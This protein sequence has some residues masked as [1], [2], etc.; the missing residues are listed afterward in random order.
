MPFFLVAVDVEIVV[1]F[2]VV[3]E[4]VDQRRV[5][6]KGED[7]RP[8]LGE[9]DVEFLIGQAVV[10]VLRGRL[11]LHE[12]DHVDHANLER[13]H[14]AAKDIHGGQRLDRRDVAGAGHDDV[15][16]APFVV[17]GP[18]P[19]PQ[20]GGAVG[21][22]RLDVE[23]LRLRLLAGDHHVDEVAAPEAMVGDG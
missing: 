7:H 21:H 1:V 3:G 6:V 14:L 10:V 15:R 16:L 8:V 17:A 19:D 4:P 11:Q 12:V 18:F 22:G 20:P 5:A 9:K 13:R 2:A 23:P